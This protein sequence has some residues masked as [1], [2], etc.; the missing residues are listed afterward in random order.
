MLYECMLSWHAGIRVIMD[1]VHSH[2]CKNEEDGMGRWDGN[3]AQY[4][5][6]GEEWETTRREDEDMRGY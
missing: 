5:H 3:S 4:F 2:A 1:L 6:A